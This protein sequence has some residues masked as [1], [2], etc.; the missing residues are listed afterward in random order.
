MLG[1]CR[2]GSL[3]TAVREL[4]KCKL[5]LVAVQEVVWDKGGNEPANDYTF[6]VKVKMLITN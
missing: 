5:D 3:R 6:S 2:S 1:I 4:V